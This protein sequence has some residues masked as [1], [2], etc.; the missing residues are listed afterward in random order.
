MKNFSYFFC[1]LLMALIGNQ[2]LSYAQGSENY[3]SGLKVNIK[4][5]GSSYIRFIVWNQIWGSVIE[6]NPGTMVNGTPENVTYDLGIRR[7]RFLAFAQIT[8]R[9]LILTHMG[10]NNQ[11]FVN[12]GVPNGG[13]TGNG[14]AFTSGKKPG[15]Y[16][17]DAWNEYAIFPAKNPETGKINKSTLYLGSGLHYWHGIS[18]MTS[19]ST[20]NFL[21]IDAP[22][23]N[24]PTIELSDQ[25]ARYFGIYA[26]GKLA[27][28]IDYRF[29]LSHPFSTNLNP[30]IVNGEKVLNTAVDNN[31]SNG[32][33]WIKAG[34]VM[35]QFMEQE[36]NLLPFTVGTYI[37]T[38]KVFNVGVGFQNQ[39]KGTISYALNTN[40]DTITQRHD[41]NMF[42]ADVFADIPFGGEKNMAVTAYSVYYLH[43]WGPNYSRSVGIMNVGVLDPSFTG[44]VAQS[45][46]GDTRPL[47]G[48]GGIWYTQ[49]G[50]LLPK[51][52][53]KKVRL[54]PF[55]AYT[56]QDLEV[57]SKPASAYDAGMNF[58]ID[59]HHAKVTLQYSSRPLIFGGVP[60]GRRG[61]FLIQTQIYL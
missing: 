58:F 21:A 25:F 44:K 11:T 51:G 36:S 24:W 15:L 20:L 34:Y 18:R 41:I 23:F 8:P 53:S 19:A 57:F 9:Y 50:L 10:I 43:N 2:Q 47:L 42:A 49:A 16:F 59:G 45:G 40:A 35:Y 61:E 32:N 60:E 38:K 48:T 13:I 17:H 27:E 6:N 39:P 37:G 4:P 5:D 7:A 12:G 52:I 33:T 1:F 3:G 26:K 31:L 22:I 14:G 56:M 29:N 55:A 54:Q 28:K 46:A 30:P